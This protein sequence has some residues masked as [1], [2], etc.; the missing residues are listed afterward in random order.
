MTRGWNL[1]KPLQDF[2]RASQEAFTVLASYDAAALT[3]EADLSDIA[4]NWV[5][6]LDEQGPSSPYPAS[7][8]GVRS[9]PKLWR[10]L[11]HPLRALVKA[12]FPS[13]SPTEEQN[14]PE[15]AYY[16]LLLDVNAILQHTQPGFGFTFAA[17]D[18]S[19]DRGVSA[20]EKY[21]GAFNTTSLVFSRSLADDVRPLIVAWSSQDRRGGVSSLPP[22]SLWAHV[23][24]FAGDP[25][26]RLQWLNRDA[27][28]GPFGEAVS[29]L[30]TEINRSQSASLT[31]EERYAKTLHGY[32]LH[33]SHCTNAELPESLCGLFV[34][35]R[36][37]GRPTAALFL[38]FDS[39]D[40]NDDAWQAAYSGAVT[41]ARHVAGVVD[42]WQMLRLERIRAASEVVRWYYH[43]SNNFN[44]DL[45]LCADTVRTVAL[46]LPESSERLAAACDAIEAIGE[47]NV[48]MARIGRAD[49][50]GDANAADVRPADFLRLMGKLSNYYGR[51]RVERLMFNCVVAPE[52]T[53]VP[54]YAQAVAIELM[55]NAVKH[56]LDGKAL[57]VDVKLG[58]GDGGIALSVISGPHA[59]ARLNQV[60][61]PGTIQPGREG[62][63]LLE[64]WTTRHRWR[65]E[66]QVHEGSSLEVQVL[67]P[68][69]S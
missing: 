26:S 69:G 49:A 42:R 21:L 1:W 5:F 38:L 53:R 20:I 45:R 62:W 9:E 33:I 18:G 55:R 19:P 46:S 60:L 30:L 43:E 57:S 41:L 61:S 58:Q 47:L 54:K 59:P 10:S 36:A 2:D 24:C 16:A 15:P 50:L 3:N 14:I 66:R 28:C 4:G 27:M 35:A 48:A 39:T 34:P 51:L 25:E 40:W 64:A 23:L 29:D 44:A 32:R 11:A 12:Q 56:R 6:A 67:F 37:A 8:G 7:S 52:V 31:L 22:G 17:F 68:L 65:L 63:R 13:G